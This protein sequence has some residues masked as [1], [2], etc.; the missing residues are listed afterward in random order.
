MRALDLVLI[1][2]AINLSI[3][4]LV[5]ADIFNTGSL[6]YE[7][8]MVDYIETMPS[9]TF[10]SN[11]PILSTLLQIQG[12]F[13]QLRG[14]FSYFTFNWIT[15]LLPVTIT[16]TVLYG[17]IITG[18]NAL[19]GILIIYAIIDILMNGVASRVI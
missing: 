18:M 14:I 10:L 16:Q 9:D 2:A 7:S 6:Y 15:G 17:S 1:I 11:I 13:N 19:L 5:Q 4:W 3:S 8:E 12:I